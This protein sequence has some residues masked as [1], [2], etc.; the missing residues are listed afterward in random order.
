MSAAVISNSEDVLSV[1]KS[2]REGSGTSM[3]CRKNL[4]LVITVSLSV[5]GLNIECFLSD[6]LF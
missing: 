6:G 5:L 1:V 2:T 4:L 3:S